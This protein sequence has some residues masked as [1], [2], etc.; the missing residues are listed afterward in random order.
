MLRKLTVIFFLF[1][2]LPLLG[3]VIQN[4]CCSGQIEPERLID[5]RERAIFWLLNNEEKI[6][7]IHNPMLWLFV[8]KAGN[9]T[10]DE[11][12]KSLF[13]DYIQANLQDLRRSV[14]FPVLTDL[15]GR[16]L[17]SSDLSGLP[18]YNLLFLYGA[19]C[20][21]SFAST[22]AVRPQ[23]ELNF[24]FIRHPFSPAC[25]THQ[26]VGFLQIRNNICRD[27]A[28]LDQSILELAEIIKWQMIFDFRVVDVYFQR[29]M[30][31][32]ESGYPEMI[33]DRWIDRFLDAQRADG[34]WSESWELMSLRSDK[35]LVQKKLGIRI[36]TPKSDF[37]A[38]AQGML[39]LAYLVDELD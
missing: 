28:E 13:D 22:D 20:D 7:K 3:G 37:H 11:R 19:T 33:N 9:I 14:W 10:G 5:A 24:C 21:E 31:L 15:P 6:N 23:L 30:M 36:A 34:G 1:I 12:L 32:Y 17:K 2:F 18:Y 39:V 38:S 29:L 26:L 25:V 35:S 16:E 8:K 4:N 27:P